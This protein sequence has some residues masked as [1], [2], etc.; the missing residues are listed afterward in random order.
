MENLFKDQVFF[1]GSIK[2]GPR[3]VI[4]CHSLLVGDNSN[5][6]SVSKFDQ[7]VQI[8]SELLVNVFN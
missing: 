2:L 6:G 4:S 1:G 7:K 5:L 3:V 8:L